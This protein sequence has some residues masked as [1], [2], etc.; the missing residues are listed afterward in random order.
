M[1]SKR[2]SDLGDRLRL[3][4]QKQELNLRLVLVIVS[5]VAGC[6]LHVNQKIIKGALHAE[7]T[8]LECRLVRRVVE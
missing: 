1:S 6:R 2:G 3:P 4:S 7:R 5:M 8:G